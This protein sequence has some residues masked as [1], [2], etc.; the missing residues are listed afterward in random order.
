[1][2]KWEPI[3]VKDPFQFLTRCAWMQVFVQD[4]TEDTCSGANICH[5]FSPRVKHVHGLVHRHIDIVVHIVQHELHHIVQ[6]RRLQTRVVVNVAEEHQ[7]E[8]VP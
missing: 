3:V 7:L 5:I 4:K 1:M 6:L 8:L 2:A